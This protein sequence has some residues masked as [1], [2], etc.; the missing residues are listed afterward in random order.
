MDSQPEPSIQVTENGPYLVTGGLEVRRAD[1]ATLETQARYALCRC[2]GSNNK[3][4]CD[5]THAKI[6]FEGT[7]T[8]DR[9]PMRD[10]QDQY[11]GNGVTI[12]DDRSVCAHA[13]FCTGGLPEVFRLRQEPWIEAARASAAVV[14]DRVK[15]CPSGALTVGVADSAELIEDDLPPCVS[16]VPDGPYRV[17]GAVQVLAADGSPY[18][19]RNRQ[20]L[21]R[22]GNSPNK[23]FCN[24]THWRIGFQAP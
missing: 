17:T 22:C 21:C 8:A 7:E 20:T 23:P 1:G 11:P 24:G 6:G 19:V 13:G 18:E 5:G 12:R 16:P 14:V 2:G 3:P 10:R 4:F 9:G 15:R